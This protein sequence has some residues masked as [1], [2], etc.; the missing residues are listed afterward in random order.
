MMNIGLGRA[1]PPYIF[2]WLFLYGHQKA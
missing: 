2:D 1:R